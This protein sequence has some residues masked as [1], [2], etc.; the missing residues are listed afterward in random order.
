MNRGFDM[1]IYL[2][3]MTVRPRPTYCADDCIFTGSRTKKRPRFTGI[4]TTSGRSCRKVALVAYF[5]SVLHDRFL[6]SPLFLWWTTCLEHQIAVGVSSSF[7]S[8]TTN[9]NSTT[10]RS[11]NANPPCPKPKRASMPVQKPSIASLLQRKTTPRRQSPTFIALRIMNPHTH[12]LA[13]SYLPQP[14][15]IWRQDFIWATM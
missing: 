5:L 6:R 14:S 4:P 13:K 3:D 8:A 11:S 2:S 15:M 7:S 9:K 10:L 1:M 12:G